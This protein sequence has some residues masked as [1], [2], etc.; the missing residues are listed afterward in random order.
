MLVKRI[1][2]TFPFPEARTDFDR[3]VR[4]FDT[5][6][7]PVTEIKPAA[8]DWNPTLE[9]AQTE[10]RII[11]KAEL[12]GV[13]PDNIEVTVEGD[14]L[15]IAGHKEEAREEQDENVFLSERI[16]GEFKR[17]V[18]LPC[19]VKD[20]GVDARFNHGVLKIRLKR[21]EAAKLK[22]I[23]IKNGS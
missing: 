5:P 3:L 22:K 6:F 16:F 1:D 4:M 12:P 23:P 11:V 15:T 9:I 7:A 19:R 20:E 18:T 10:D 13:D 8:G 2:R 17:M 21:K 14:V